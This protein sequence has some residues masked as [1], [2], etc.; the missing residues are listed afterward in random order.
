MMANIFISYSRSDKARVD[1]LIDQL[2]SDGHQVWIDR[3]GIRGG[4]QWRRQIVEAIEKSD[5]FLLVLSQ[6][7]VQSDN[8]RTEIDLAKDSGKKI[9]PVEI[10][11]I[12]IPSSMK[13]QLVGL[14]RIDL[15]TDYSDGFQN[16]L[17]TLGDQQV[18]ETAGAASTEKL[19]DR[20]PSRIR[21]KKVYISGMIVFAVL[22]PAIAYLFNNTF[23]GSPGSRSPIETQ[24]VEISQNTP[25]S[26]SATK[27]PYLQTLAVRKP[28]LDQITTIDDLEPLLL[29][30]NIRLSEPEDEDRTR[31]YFTGPDSA[32]HMLGVASLNVVGDQRFKKYINLDIVD[33]WYTRAVGSGYA[34]RG[35]LDLEIVEQ[36]LI[37]AHNDYW[38][39]NAASLDGLLE[40][41]K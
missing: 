31:S 28:E 4:E 1:R 40:P 24:T 23:T 36:S 29:E 2:E 35:P 27:N 22:L 30:A 41:L 32:Y 33:K 38:G 9:A 15:Y 37:D 5:L 11:R 19:P 39:G 10:Q 18:S 21:P 6:N 8:V 17:I 25:A 26:P 14:Q 20:Y 13:Y 34:S 3:A 16:L 7:S 12:E